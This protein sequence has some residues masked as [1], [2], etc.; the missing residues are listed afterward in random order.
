METDGKGLQI[1]RQD[2]ISGFL[3]VNLGTIKLENNIIQTCL[4][5]RYPV[6]ASYDEIEQG[7][8]KVAEEKNLQLVITKHKKSLYIPK[9]SKLVKTLQ[10]VYTE[11]TGREEEPLTTGGGTYAKEMDNIVAFGMLFPEQEDVM[12]QKNEYM[13]IEDLM[14]NVEIMAKAMVELAK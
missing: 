14:K 12:H 8:K 10:H 11:V 7:L 3:T 4:D 9:D 1:N 6:T 13:S 2:E 5:I